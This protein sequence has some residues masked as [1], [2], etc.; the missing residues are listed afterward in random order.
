MPVETVAEHDL[1]LCPRC[2]ES[3]EKGEEVIVEH[4]CPVHAED[5]TQEAAIVECPQ[6]PGIPATVGAGTEV[7]RT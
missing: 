1:G 4:G 3:I 6:M 5:C 2:G 7:E